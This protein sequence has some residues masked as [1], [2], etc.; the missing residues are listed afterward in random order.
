MVT[1][2]HELA[3]R[4]RREGQRRLAGTGQHR[5]Q[6]GRDAKKAEQLYSRRFPAYAKS[7]VSHQDEPLAA[8]LRS[9]SLFRF[10]PRTIKVLDESEFG[11]A[12]FVTVVMNKGRDSK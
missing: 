6:R 8:Q 4:T 2:R 11:H 9:C 1:Q 7:I 5:K 10:V 12:V 3:L